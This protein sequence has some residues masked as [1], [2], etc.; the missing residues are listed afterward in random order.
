[1]DVPAQSIA[2]ATNAPAPPKDAATPPPDTTPHDEPADAAAKSARDDATPKGLWMAMFF[3]FLGGLILNVMPCVLPVIS[4][5]VISFMQQGGEEPGRVL[6]LGLAFCAGI[7]VW[8]WAF[9]LLSSRGQFPLQYPGVVLGVS[10]ILFV[11]ALNLFGVFEISLPGAAVGKLDEITHREGYAGAFFKGLLATLLGTACTAPFLAG[12]L[13]YAATHPFLDVML[14]FTA[15]GLGMSAPYLLLSM[16]PKWLVFV[17]KPGPWMITF[18]QA[19]GFVLLGTVVW[20]L[21][22]LSSQLDADAVVWTVG[23]WGF[24]GLAAWMFGKAQHARAGTTR[25]VVSAL[26]LAVLAVGYWFSFERMYD[27][28]AV[29]RGEA[30]APPATADSAPDD[31]DAVVRSV[32]QRGWD[33]GIPWVH[34]RPGLAEAL[35]RAGYTVYVDYTATWCTTCLANKAAV[36]ETKYIREQMRAM[37]VIPIE[38]DFTKRDPALLAEIQSFNRPSVPVNVI[39]PANRPDDVIVLPVVLTQATVSEALRSAGPSIGADR[40]TADI[41]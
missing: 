15:A 27:L 9:A 29:L 10:T 33:E 3:A 17:P 31:L 1:P 24:V 40:L 37:G 8:F 2:S 4:I 19:M 16:N 11:F 23:F 36:L 35:A 18:K 32:V 34:H 13:V 26:T 14:V 28:R 25:G 21:W 5:K 20:L 12:A 22:V 7:M 38:A 41:P 6:R 30:A 39:Y